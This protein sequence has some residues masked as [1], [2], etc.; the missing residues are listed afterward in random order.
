MTLWKWLNFGA[1][2]NPDVD[3]RSLFHFHKHY[4]IRLDTIY[5]HSLEGA[6]T[7]LRDNAAAMAE[8]ALSEHI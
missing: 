2:P 6:T 8:F 4:E 5:C 3:L 1:D 7:L